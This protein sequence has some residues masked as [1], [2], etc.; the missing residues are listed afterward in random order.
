MFHVK[1]GLLIS[2]DLRRKQVGASPPDLAG[3]PRQFGRRTQVIRPSHDVA[4]QTEMARRIGASFS[5]QSL[6]LSCSLLN[7]TR[8]SR[9][10]SV[11]ILE[12][13]SFCSASRVYELPGEC[14]AVLRYFHVF[15]P[16]PSPGAGWTGEVGVP[17]Y[18]GISCA[19][20]RVSV[21]LSGCLRC[22]FRGP[23]SA[24]SDNGTRVRIVPP[25]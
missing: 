7:L 1:H 3:G 16:G 22:M 12:P 2:E 15:E 18:I 11:P 8:A 9:R 14:S 23:S 21:L 17:L 4:E 6:D 5:R 24:R 13:R 20:R 10:A 19:S 25:A